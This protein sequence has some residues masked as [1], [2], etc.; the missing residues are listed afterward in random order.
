MKLTLIILWQCGSI[1]NNSSTLRM[2]WEIDR[3]RWEQSKSWGTSILA[4]YTTTELKGDPSTI[5]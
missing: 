3:E 1:L 4:V 5:R 2:R